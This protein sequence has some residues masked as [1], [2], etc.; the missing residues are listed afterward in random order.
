MSTRKSHGG[1]QSRFAQ[2][3]APQGMRSTFD[4][5]CSHK[6]TFD[7]GDLVPIFV[8]ETIPGDT[9]SI[10]TTLMGRLATPVKPVMDNMFLECFFFFVPLRLVWDN[11]QKMMGEQVDPG[12]ST[13]FLVP[14]LVADGTAGFIERSVMDHMGV[15]TKVPNLRVSALYKRAYHLVWNEWFRSEDLQD[16]V[17]VPRDDGPDA[18][19]F[20]ATLLKRGKRHDY[21]TASLPFLQKG[22]DVALPLGTVAPVVSAGDGQPSFDADDVT[23]ALVDVIGGGPAAGELNL[24]TNP[25]NTG[26]L[27]WNQTKLEADL[28]AATAATINAMREAITLQQLYERDARG[29]TRYTEIIRSHFGVVSPDQRLQ[30][31]EYLG[32]CQT[33][34]DVMQ[35]PKTAEDGTDPQ[36]NLAAYATAVKTAR[37]FTKTFTE[38]GI[39]LGLVAGRAELTYQEGVER[40]FSR[41]TRFDFYWPDLANLGEQAVKNKEIY[42]QGTAADDDPFGYQERWA[43][44]RYKPSRVTG[45]FRSNAAQSLDVWHL[46]QEFGA[47]PALNATFIEE[48]PPI[49]RVVAVPS[50]PDM[51]MDCHFQFRAVRPL[52]VYSVPGLKRL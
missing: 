46:A 12:D 27:T 45:L 16:S 17:T 24:A 8:E 21:F 6:T 5:S 37:G 29:G 15:P 11:F 42:A 49:D 14:E 25:T 28:S 31:P 47:L 48:Q 22:P 44:M 1:A 52:P 36:G 13:D 35:V 41:R 50:E 23:D 30:R 9:F 18:E 33:R 43:E 7:F 32:G 38:H 19:V 34:V 20:G 4:R 10:E 2:V 40:Q 51:I 3:P 26:T 39:V